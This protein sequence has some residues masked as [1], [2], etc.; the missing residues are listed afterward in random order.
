MLW[1]LFIEHNSMST[2]GFAARQ[3]YCDVLHDGFYAW[4][5][6]WLT[7]DC[8]FLK[9]LQFV[10]SNVYIFV[11]FIIFYFIHRVS[12]QVLVMLFICYTQRRFLLF[13]FD[14]NAIKIWYFKQ[15]LYASFLAYWDI[16]VNGMYLF[17]NI[18]KQTNE[19]HIL[20]A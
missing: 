14:L 20:I 5:L 8:A 7:F 11:L 19:L 9:A 15:W 18:H 2:N 10:L 13:L 4:T 16:P 12:N 1:F 17:Y 6:F 3:Y